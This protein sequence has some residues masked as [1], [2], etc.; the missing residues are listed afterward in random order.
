MNDPEPA[1]K[2]SNGRVLLTFEEINDPE[3][4]SLILSKNEMGQ[5]AFTHLVLATHEPF[6]AFIGRQLRSR[7][8]CHEVLQ[9]VYMAVYKGLAGY[10]GKSKLTTWIY[11]LA[12]HKICDRISKR[13]RKHIEQTQTRQDSL[14][15]ETNEFGSFADITSW[16]A[17]PDLILARNAIEKLIGK[18]IESLPQAIKK[19]YQLRDI[20]GFSGEEAGE[21]LGITPENI[22][23]QLHRAR[24]QI[25]EWV[26]EKMTKPQ[27]SK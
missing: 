1:S 26:Q 9:E 5:R 22:R 2:A 6:L 21:I 10:A 27:V 13:D 8:E 20:E 7:E 23:V 24:R 18:A 15:T 17:A 4:L 19:V 11:A 3:F 14:S 25:V 16:D 12:Y